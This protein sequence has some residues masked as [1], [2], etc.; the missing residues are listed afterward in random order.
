MK[1][2]R[3]TC[4]VCPI[5]CKIVANKKDDKIEI[6]GGN[7]CKRGEKYAIDEILHPKRMVTTSV[8]VKN[9]EYPLVSVRTSQPVPKE[10]VMEI[11][12]EM[13]KISLEAPVK[14][15]DVIVKNV[16]GTDADII[17]TRTVNSI[18]NSV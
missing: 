16:A 4:I 14:C 10:K 18:P 7:K 1:K 15:G 5:G 12:K 11:V 8:F 17:A 9:G 13:K 3:I 2:I 6:V